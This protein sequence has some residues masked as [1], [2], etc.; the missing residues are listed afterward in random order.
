MTER[1][2]D[3]KTGR[4]KYRETEKTEIQRGRKDRKIERQKRQ[5]IRKTEQTNKT[6]KT[7]YV[8]NIES[9]INQQLKCNYSFMQQSKL[10]KQNLR[11][12]FNANKTK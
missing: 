11:N 5:K 12:F 7:R 4:Q 3:R 8:D 9:I 2:K 6:K 1:Q 10:E